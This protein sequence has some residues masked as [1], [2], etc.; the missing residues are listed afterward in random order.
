MK[1]GNHQ[2]KLGYRLKGFT[3]TE[4]LIVLLIIGILILIALPDQTSVINKAKAK[5]AQLQ[6]R[7]VHTLQKSYFYEHGKYGESLKDIG[8]QQV[9]TVSD[10]GSANYQISLELE[11]DGYKAYAVSVVDFDRDGAYNT[12]TIDQD[13]N[14]I[15]E[16]QD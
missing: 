4:I 8:F 16:I 6:L 9:P 3:L 14:L 1:K 10:G 5:E 11:K 15:E 12:W 13:L 2:S 7:H